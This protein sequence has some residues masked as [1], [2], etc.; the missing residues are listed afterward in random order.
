LIDS[1]FAA[2]PAAAGVAA[3]G[4]VGGGI[5]SGGAGVAAGVSAGAALAEATGV[6]SASSLLFCLQA[7]TRS[8]ATMSD[9]RISRGTVPPN[10]NHLYR[11]IPVLW[12]FASWSEPRREGWLEF[13]GRIDHEDVAE[14]T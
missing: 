2:P 3:G 12:Q 9:V 14:D 7:E 8:A 11:K 6:G 13:D 10:E 1:A 5:V 4:C